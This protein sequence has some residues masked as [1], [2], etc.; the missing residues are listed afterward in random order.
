MLKEIREILYQKL[1]FRAARNNDVIT[2]SILIST[3]NKLSS[4]RTEIQ[5]LA[6]YKDHRGKIPIQVAIDHKN[7]EVAILLFRNTGIYGWGD[8]TPFGELV[9]FEGVCSYSVKFINQL[10]RYK[11]NLD[12][13]TKDGLPILHYVT[14]NCSE[15]MVK[16]LLENGASVKTKDSQ[17]NTALHTVYYSLQHNISSLGSEELVMAFRERMYEIARLLIKY[18]AD[19]NL[20]DMRGEIPAKRDTVLR[21]FFET[22]FLVK[23][24]EDERWTRV[25]DWIAICG[26]FSLK[27]SADSSDKTQVNQIKARSSSFTSSLIESRKRPEGCIIAHYFD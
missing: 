11:K 4:N 23:S 25:K 9:T 1:F 13:C 10:I 26:G 16:L 3:L 17:G 20:P 24:R 7:I 14:Y 15:E 8:F 22:E 6:R 2:L 5:R 21:Q 19:I 18:G 27:S 12:L